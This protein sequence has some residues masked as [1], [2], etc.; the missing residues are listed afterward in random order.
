MALSHGAWMLMLHA[1]RHHAREALNFNITVMIVWIGG[2][3][4]PWIALVTNMNHRSGPVGWFFVMFGVAM[5]LMFG[6]FACSVI[7]AIRASQGGWWRYPV[8]IRLVGRAEDRAE[9][10]ARDG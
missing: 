10:Q 8:S 9:R 4:G 5:L 2:F 7:G 3:M 1:Y 6:A